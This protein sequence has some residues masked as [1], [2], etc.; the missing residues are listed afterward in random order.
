[1]NKSH[2]LLFNLLGIASI[3][4]GALQLHAEPPKSSSDFEPVDD[5]MHHLMEYVFEPSYKRLKASMAEEP[6]DK[7][8]WKAIKGDSLSL[9]EVAN[10]LLHRL[11]QENAEDWQN[12]TV[13]TR[14]AG[15]EFYQAA[16]AANYPEALEAYRVMLKRCN[17]C[18]DQFADGEHQLEP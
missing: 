13:E 14:K 16:R 5:D 15:G 7:A 2:I 18:H 11:P 17:A 12:H 3:Y 6:S 4:L 1:M 10:L 8:V 9:A